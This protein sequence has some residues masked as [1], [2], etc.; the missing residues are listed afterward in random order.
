MIPDGMNE[1]VRAA[2]LQGG[3]VTSDM[4]KAGIPMLTGCDG[5]IADS[6]LQDELA[7]LVRGGMTSADALK[8][9]PLIA[10]SPGQALLRIPTCR[11]SELLFLPSVPKIL[12]SQSS[13]PQKKESGLRPGTSASWV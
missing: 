6:C 5:V 12:G 9:P 10:R 3:V 11:Q 13:R 2:A 7:A 8:P 1:K 4:A